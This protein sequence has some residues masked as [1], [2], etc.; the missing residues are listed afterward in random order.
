MSRLTKTIKGVCV[1]SA[2]LLLS[3]SG[4]SSANPATSAKLNDG[5]ALRGELPANPLQWRVVSMTVDRAEGTTS[6]LY[7]NDIAVEYARANPQGDY[8]V[9]SQLAVVTWTQL[10]DPRWFGAKIPASVKSIEFITAEKV[11]NGHS[12]FAYKKFGGNPLKEIAQ[13]ASADLDGRVSFIA[14]QRAAVLP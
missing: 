3:M 7:G 8:P 9:G 10:E 1:S 5:A 13:P 4:C 12:I 11:V 14:S 6:T 2:L